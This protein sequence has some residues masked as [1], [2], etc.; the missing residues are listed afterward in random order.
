MKAGVAG[1]K[2]VDNLERASGGRKSGPG[3]K[4]MRLKKC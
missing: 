2:R 1:K 3:G 4:S